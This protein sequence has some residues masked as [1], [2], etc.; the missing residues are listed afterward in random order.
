MPAGIGAGR[1]QLSALEP[2]VVALQSQPAP[3]GVAVIVPAGK[4]SVT[5][6][7]EPTGPTPVPRSV[8]AVSVNVPL[9]PVTNGPLFDFSS[10]SRGSGLMLSTTSV[11]ISWM[12]VLPPV[13]ALKPNLN[14]GGGFGGSGCRSTS[15]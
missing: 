12:F 4:V 8:P 15:V 5:V 2:V 6:T 7:G 3:L 14:V 11:R 1:V 13:E 10:L 9:P